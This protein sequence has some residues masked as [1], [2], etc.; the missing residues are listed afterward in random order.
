MP[1]PE[2]LELTR[3]LLGLMEITA[4]HAGK[5]TAHVLR[6]S[7]AQIRQM[8]AEDKRLRSM[9]A[10][11]VDARSNPVEKQFAMDDIHDEVNNW[12]KNNTGLDTKPPKR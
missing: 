2:K 10:R 8:M 6:T 3:D 7:A 12:R 1:T 5:T 4:S 11:V 9:M